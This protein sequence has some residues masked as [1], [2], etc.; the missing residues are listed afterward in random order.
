MVNLHNQANRPFLNRSPSHFLPMFLAEIKHRKFNFILATLAVTAAVAVWLTAKSSL[1]DFD[2]TTETQLTTLEEKTTAEM[3][4]L[5]DDIRKTMKGL[6]FNVFL[7]PAGEELW[8]IK[9]RGYSE[10]TMPQDSVDKLAESKIVTVNH[11][12]PQLSRRIQWQE[13]NRSILL[14]GIEGQV[15]IAHRSGPKKKK[16]IMSPLAPGSI[17]LGHDLHNSLGLKKGDTLTLNGSSYKIAETFPPRNF[18]DDGSAWIHLAQAQKIFGLENQINAILALGCNCASIDRLGEIRSEISTIL[19]DVQI[20]ELGSSALVRAEARNKAGDRARQ[21]K[22]TISESRQ[23]ARAERARFSSILSPLIA[24]GA[25]LALAYLAFTNVRERLPEI[26]TLRAIGVSHLKIATLL[27]ARAALIGLLATALVFLISKATAFH[28][29]P[30]T[31]L[32]IPLA[33]A[34]A[35]WLPTLYALTKDPVTILRHD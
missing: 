1:A 35:A 29:P 16:P 19:P 23:A 11:L 30:I 2:Q 17:N 20:I 10:K 34:A 25:F 27:L 12:L 18:L 3:K 32:L 14:V 15:P 7:F 31:W 26:G 22:K 13:K 33:S 28:L 24:A 4:S 9:E 8:Q 21:A 5:E 6:G